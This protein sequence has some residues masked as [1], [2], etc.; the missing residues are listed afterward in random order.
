MA[1]D[2]GKS[3][4]GA[5]DAEPEYIYTAILKNGQ[6]ENFKATNAHKANMEAE[7][8]HGYANISVAP[9]ESLRKPHTESQSKNE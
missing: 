1:I 2:G 4:F 6:K 9:Q 7:K 5:M 8:K 3:V